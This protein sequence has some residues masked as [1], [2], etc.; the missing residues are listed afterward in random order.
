[1]IRASRVYRENNCRLIRRVIRS[2]GAI[3]SNDE[4][5]KY[6]W[7]RMQARA[8]AGE[9]ALTPW[10][11]HDVYPTTNPLPQGH[12][13]R[14]FS[15]IYVLYRSEER[16]ERL[17]PKFPNIITLLPNISSPDRD[18]SGSFFVYCLI[19]RGPW[20][21]SSSLGIQANQFHKSFIF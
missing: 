19:Q 20:D 1:M 16:K 11:L 7:N 9:R 14:P 6:L 4:P 17:S 5:I 12:A 3:K 10:W 13:L 15:Q 21:C 2:C 18:H 8:D